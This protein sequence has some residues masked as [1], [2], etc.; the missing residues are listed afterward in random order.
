MPHRNT[1]DFGELVGFLT[2]TLSEPLTMVGEIDVTNLF[3]IEIGIN[4]ALVAEEGR[5]AAK[6][7]AVEP[8]QDKVD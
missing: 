1:L 8:R 3:P 4:A 6:A 2:E 7:E 5:F